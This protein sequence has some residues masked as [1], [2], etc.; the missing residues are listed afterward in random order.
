MPKHSIFAKYH[1]TTITSNLLKLCPAIRCKMSHF[2]SYKQKYL[3]KSHKK[4]TCFLPKEKMAPAIQFVKKNIENHSCPL[5]LGSVVVYKLKFWPIL[6]L[7]MQTT[8]VCL[9]CFLNSMIVNVLMVNDINV[10]IPSAYLG[11]QLLNI[12]GF[13]YLPFLLHLIFVRWY[14]LCFF[15]F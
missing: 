12:W 3:R 1:S 15:N 9:V 4:H 7:S 13:S 10:N 14:F 11:F 2:P 5:L 8:E 6:L